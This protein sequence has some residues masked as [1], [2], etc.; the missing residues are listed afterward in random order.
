FARHSLTPC[1]D[2]PGCQSTSEAF[3]SAS[4]ETVTTDSYSLSLHDAL[5]IFSN[6]SSTAARVKRAMTAAPEKPSVMT[7]RTRCAAVALPELD[8]KSTRLNSSHVKIS[9][10]VFCLK[11]K[12]YH[13]IPVSLITR[14]DL[15]IYT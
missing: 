12:N 3:V 10:A 1:H 14:H 2:D 13:K 15:G 5:P 8:R 11:K 6:T 4:T 9:Y 7:G